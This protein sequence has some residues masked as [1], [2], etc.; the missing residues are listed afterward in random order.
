MGARD[1]VGG[2]IVQPHRLLQAAHRLIGQHGAQPGDISRL[3]DA[4]KPC[5]RRQLGH[6]WD[7]PAA[8]GT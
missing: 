8:A 4:E 1:G 3:G 6:R 5:G 7:A 2:G